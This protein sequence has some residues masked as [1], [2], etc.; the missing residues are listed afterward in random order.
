MVRGEGPA[1]SLVLCAVRALPDE[2]MTVALSAGGRDHY[3]WGMDR[4]MIANVY[5]ALNLNTRATGNWGKGKPPKLAEYPRPKSK[6]AGDAA[7][8]KQPTVR[9][10]FAQMTAKG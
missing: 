9:D 10:I 2:S 1:P 5:D 6:P 8:A 3:G 7:P 4:H